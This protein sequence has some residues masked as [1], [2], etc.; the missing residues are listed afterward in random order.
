MF[1]YVAGGMGDATCVGNRFSYF[2]KAT[3]GW[4]DGEANYEKTADF[5]AVG[6]AFRADGWFS[7]SQEVLYCQ[8]ELATGL[9]KEMHLEISEL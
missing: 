9:Y 5:D 1:G 7:E 8:S 6:C 3:S 2:Q 4:N